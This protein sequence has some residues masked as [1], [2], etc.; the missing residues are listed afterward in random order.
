VRRRRDLAAEHN[1]IGQSQLLD[2]F[3]KLG[4]HAM[5]DPTRH[6]SMAPPESSHYSNGSRCVSSPFAS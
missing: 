4:A 1:A 6:N 3:P 2:E 5:P